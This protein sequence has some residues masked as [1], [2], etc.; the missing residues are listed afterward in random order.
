MRRREFITIVG[1]AATWPLAARAQRQ[2]RMRRIALL[3][4][5]AEGDTSALSDLL[6]FRQVLG[7]LGWMEGQNIQF[8]YRWAASDADR[9]RSYARELVGL[10][11]DVIVANTL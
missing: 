9:M 2:E 3:M 8:E 11:P 5:Y 7:E 4:N 6:A 1:G 10:A